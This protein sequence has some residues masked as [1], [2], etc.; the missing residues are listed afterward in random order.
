MVDI[1][2]KVSICIPT[3][4]Q[5]FYLVKNLDS[6]LIQDYEN[7]EVIITDDTPDDSLKEV[8]EPYL[9]MFKG[10]LRYY[11]NNIAL[12]SPD[13]WNEAVSKAKGEYI[14]ILHHD[15]WFAS[16]TCLRTFVEALDKEPQSSAAF[17]STLVLSPNGEQRVHRINLSSFEQIKADPCSLLLANYVGAPSV[18]IYR[19]RRGLKYDSK[20]KWL[21]DVDFYIRL[22]IENPNIIFIE[23]PLIVNTADAPHQVTNY[24]KDNKAIELSEYFYLFNKIKKYI[25]TDRQPYYRLLTWLLNHHGLDTYLNYLKDPAKPEI[26][27]PI[28]VIA[29]LLKN[30]LKRLLLLRK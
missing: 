24:C 21:V 17:S 13:N 25:T 15:D 18:L 4:K 10:R 26:E 19:N 27:L 14:K 6:I 20:L 2:P 5:V 12:G 30:D 23:E 28:M 11:K 9:H 3:Y 29:R 1:N 16:S 8:V 7:Y 22:F